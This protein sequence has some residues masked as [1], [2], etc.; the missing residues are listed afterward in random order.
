MNM[1][2][3]AKHRDTL[4]PP[5]PFVCECEECKCCICCKANHEEE[6]CDGWCSGQ[7]DCDCI[8]DYLV[9]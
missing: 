8:D 3:C 6:G 1:E 4:N 5:Y 7:W 9:E 2:D